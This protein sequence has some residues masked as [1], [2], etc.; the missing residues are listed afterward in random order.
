MFPSANRARESQPT[1]RFSC[2]ASGLLKSLRPT[3]SELDPGLIGP[4]E[5]SGPSTCFS[6]AALG[7]GKVIP[8]RRD[9][10]GLRLRNC[11]DEKPLSAFAPL[12]Q[13]HC[14]SLDHE[15]ISPMIDSQR[16]AS[17]LPTTLP[18]LLVSPPLV[19]PV[20]PWSSPAHPLFSLLIHNFALCILCNICALH[21][22][23]LLHLDT[24]HTLHDRIRTVSNLAT[25][26]FGHGLRD[27]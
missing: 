4:P 7:V 15:E 2:L 14:Y 1:R 18:L 20:P 27:P 8:R 9:W 21:H 11:R 19:K 23:I 13:P 24:Y 3:G 16:K 6:L 17:G 25:A 22:S 12:K 5:E 10:L 26:T